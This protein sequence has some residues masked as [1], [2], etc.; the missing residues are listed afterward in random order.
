MYECIPPAKKQEYDKVDTVE[1]TLSVEQY[2]G[3][4]QI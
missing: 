2:S 4:K 3:V 1:T